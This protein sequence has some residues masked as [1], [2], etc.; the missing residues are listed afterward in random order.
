M[1]EVLKG[2]H[3]LS[4]RGVNAYLIDHGQLTLID[5]GYADNEGKIIDYIHKIGKTIDDLEN[6]IVTHLHTDHSGSLAGL[7]ELSNAKIYAHI[8]DVPLIEQGVSFRESLEISPGLFNHLIFR[9]FIKNAPRNIKPVQVDYRI[10]ESEERLAIGKGF[11][12]IT[13]PGHARGQIALLYEDQKGVLFAADTCGNMGGLRLAPFYEDY[14]QGQQDIQTLSR[15][16]FESILFGHGTPILKNALQ[17]FRKKFRKLIRDN[18]G[19]QLATTNT[20]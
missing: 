17:I 6:I 2:I 10:E 15:L 18:S 13:V 20:V 19:L 9:L 3:L 16:Q 12:I 14:R 5:T 4:L 7:K 11:R 1:K 8:H